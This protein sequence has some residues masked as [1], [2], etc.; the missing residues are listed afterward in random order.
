MT[1]S[2]LGSAVEAAVGTGIGFLVSWA[3]TP[4]ILGW[5]GY[6]A[7]AGAAFGITVVYTVLSFAR[8]WV[9]RRAFNRLHMAL[10]RNVTPE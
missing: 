6:S 9:V 8:S 1:Q 2:R 3:C 10:D 4:T 5:F 7:G